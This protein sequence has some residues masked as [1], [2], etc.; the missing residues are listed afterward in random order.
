MAEAPAPRL[1]SLGPDEVLTEPVE[2][3]RPPFSG[4]KE[5]I[6]TERLLAG[7]RGIQ[8]ATLGPDREPPR[9]A[10]EIFSN[11]TATFLRSAAACLLLRDLLGD[12]VW[13]GP[14][15]GRAVAMEEE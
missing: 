12:A 9:A 4:F 3:R 11:P 13:R 2:P 8:P 15:S 14:A 10:I 7:A 6:G 1:P 5:A